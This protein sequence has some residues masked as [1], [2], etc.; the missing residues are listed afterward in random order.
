LVETDYENVRETSEQSGSLR[1]HPNPEL[2]ACTVSS[3][4]VVGSK[5]FNT[6]QP[7]DWQ[8]NITK[9]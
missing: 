7:Q 6:K 5:V 4:S 3:Q 8:K 9:T 2:G 1:P